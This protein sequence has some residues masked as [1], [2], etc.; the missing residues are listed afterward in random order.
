MADRSLGERIRLRRQALKWT[1][2]ELADRLDVNR[3]TV[4]AWERN[5]QRPDRTEGAIEDVLG[6]SLLNG[7]G[8]E[9]YTDPVERA[10][11]DDLTL[12]SDE[13]RRGL[14]FDLRR[15]KR[16]HARRTAL[17]PAQ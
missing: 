4:S 14:I 11:W 7:T 5:K 8:P 16:E 3:A 1:Q 10:V 15:A 9:V 13:E 17:P 6:I 12:G 2:Q